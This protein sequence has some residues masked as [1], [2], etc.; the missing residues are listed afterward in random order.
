MLPNEDAA[1]RHCNENSNDND[2]APK[3]VL[4]SK[5]VIRITLKESNF[6]SK[7]DSTNDYCSYQQPPI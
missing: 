5:P 4:D 2:Y 3:C 1:N 7:Y 6:C